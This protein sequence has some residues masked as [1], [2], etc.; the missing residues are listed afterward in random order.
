MKQPRALSPL[1]LTEMW[2]RFGFYVVQSL[3]IL[4][5]T[6]IL[7][8]NDTKSY[9]LLGE[10]TALVYLAPLAGGFFSDR[11]LGPRYSILVGAIFLAIGYY[12]LAAYSHAMLFLSLAFIVIGNGFLK[13][14]ISSFLGEF[15]YEDDPRRDAGFTLF[16]IGINIGALL[17]LGGGGFIQEKWGWWA[18]FG[19]AGVGMTIGL[20][21]FCFGFSTFENRGLPV[22]YDQI[23]SKV[24]R[25]LSRKL[26]ISVLIL[27]CLGIALLLLRSSRAAEIIQVLV[28]ILIVITLIYTATRYE[29]HQRNRLFALII[30]ILA[31]VI[32]WG[33]FFQ[34][35]ASVNLFT[36]RDVDRHVFGFLLPPSAFLSLESLFILLMGPFLAWL[37]QR[38]HVK[39]KDLTP[40]VKFSLGLFSITLAMLLLVIGIH[41]PNQQG[42]TSSRW[43]IVFFV[44][45]TLGEML[46]S[47][48][49]LS[50]VTELSPPKLSGLM[51][52]VW[53][54]GIGFGGELSGHLATQASVPKGLHQAVTKTSLIYSN[55]FLHDALLAF[56][57]GVVLLAI[58]PWLKRLIDK[59]HYN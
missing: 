59:N 42:F 31:S 57:T 13:P 37:W 29:K 21:T 1:F 40:G 43:I 23:K 20:I 49:G 32:F 33:L 16:Y 27:I 46:L 28:G 41:F 17:A 52:G 26:S 56:I 10:F 55:A 22:P 3:L 8:F 47:P 51:M 5:L 19:S 4:Y 12:L 45:A 39:K 48:I 6:N 53:F 38:L 50:M 9:T 11:V 18:A 35:F 34:M 2:E 58:S 54:M 25:F 14:N 24:L 44:F 15:Y 30:L 7:N 36:E